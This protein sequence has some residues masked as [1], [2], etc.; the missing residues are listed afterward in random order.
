MHG[1]W[2]NRSKALVR[3]HRQILGGKLCMDSTKIIELLQKTIKLSIRLRERTEWI[4]ITAIYR[5]FYFAI[6]G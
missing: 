3:I 2:S 4:D 1:R 6:N 5:T